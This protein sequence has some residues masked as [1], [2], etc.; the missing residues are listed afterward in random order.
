MVAGG[1]VKLPTVWSMG[2]GL[3]GFGSMVLSGSPSWLSTPARVS[4]HTAD[5]PKYDPLYRRW[6]PRLDHHEEVLRPL[7]GWAQMPDH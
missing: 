4:P 3:G 5:Y 7:T 1:L 2:G 6:P